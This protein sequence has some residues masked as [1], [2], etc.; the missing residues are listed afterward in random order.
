MHDTA[1]RLASLA[2]SAPPPDHS[3]LIALLGVTG[4]VL[5]SLIGVWAG[6]R[7]RDQSD[8][9]GRQGRSS[10]I[11]ALAAQRESEHDA[12]I[13]IN[14]WRDEQMRRR[15]LERFLWIRRYDPTKIVTGEEDDDDVRIPPRET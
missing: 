5:A 15:I 3:V 2:D 7:T 12:A 14:D 4:L 6:T 11:S 13:A 1:A 9:R 8:D 10:L